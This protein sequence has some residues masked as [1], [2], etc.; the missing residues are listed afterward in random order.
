[1]D[2]DLEFMQR[3]QE[4][5][6]LALNAL[7]GRWRTPLISFILRYLGNRD[8]AM[9]LAQETFV[10]VYE[11]RHSFR[12]EAKFSSWLFSIAANLCR[13]QLRW[14]SRHPA[15]S[16]DADEEEN[17]ARQQEDS[18]PSPSEDA[19]QRDLALAVQKEI[20]SLPHDLRVA[21]LLSVY[22]ERPHGE[23]AQV[24]GCSAKAV[25]SRLYRAR[26]ILRGA[27]KKWE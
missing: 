21:I 27:L 10:R 23:I 11:H 17:D 26:E 5:D 13:N 24:L 22:E 14:R 3:L 12:K 4:G 7:M 8:D 16:L 25:E 1:M 18:A 19:E 15:V 6:D 9:D 2:P 20:Q